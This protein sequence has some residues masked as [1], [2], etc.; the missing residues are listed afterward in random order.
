MPTFNDHF[1]AIRAARTSEQLNAATEAIRA[2]LESLDAQQKARL[3]SLRRTHA[4]A[5]GLFGTPEATN[6]IT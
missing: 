3:E 6:S 5:L 2:D 4:L 1:A